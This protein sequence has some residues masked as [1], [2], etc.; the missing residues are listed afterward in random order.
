M[1]NNVFQSTNV[2]TSNVAM[3]LND[4]SMIWNVG[5]RTFGNSPDSNVNLVCILWWKHLLH[6]VV[7]RNRAGNYT[8]RKKYIN[9]VTFYIISKC[10]KRTKL[11]CKKL[12]FVYVFVK[13]IILHNYWVK[14]TWSDLCKKYFFSWYLL[15]H[16]SHIS[17]IS[18]NYFTSSLCFCCVAFPE[19]VIPNMNYIS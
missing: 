7:I 17:C 16:F 12:H 15:H 4:L 9:Y 10:V 19:G 1:A 6:S 2:C 5:I 13:K 3:Q 14:F 8:Q 18:R 11:S